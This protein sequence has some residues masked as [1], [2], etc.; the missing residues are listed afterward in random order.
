MLAYAAFLSVLVM[1]M[2]VGTGHF[3][4]KW[5]LFGGS[6]KTLNTLVGIQ[7]QSHSLVYLQDLALFLHM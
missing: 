4:I 2:L 7:D 6:R 3:W 5:K 1:N